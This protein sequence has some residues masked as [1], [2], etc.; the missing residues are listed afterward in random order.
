MILK[1]FFC[2]SEG[3]FKILFFWATIFLFI[4]V[5]C[6]ITE[7]VFQIHYFRNDTKPVVSLI[8]LIGAL[9][10]L[11]TFLIGLYNWSKKIKNGNST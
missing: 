4:T 1:S 6:I 3:K 7:I 9:L 11:V 2:D 5:V 10:G 8:T